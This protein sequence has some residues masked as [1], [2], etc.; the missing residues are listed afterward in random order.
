MKKVIVII[1][2][3][4]LLLVVGYFVYNYLFN[5]NIPLNLKDKEYSSVASDWIQKTDNESG[6]SFKYPSNWLADEVEGMTFPTFLNATAND[7]YYIVQF[8]LSPNSSVDSEIEYD[9][10]IR[11]AKKDTIIIEEI[12]IGGKSA[13]KVT[14]SFG[15]KPPASGNFIISFIQSGDSVLKIVLNDTKYLSIYNEILDDIT[16]KN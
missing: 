4:L 1:V 14:G 8:H 6:I 15:E 16:F 2:S 9:A 13:K 7:E 3:L 5:S 11:T 10:T 12:I